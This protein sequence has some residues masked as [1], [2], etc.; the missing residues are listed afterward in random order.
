VY[1]SIK[2][3]LVHA[4]EKAKRW[5]CSRDHRFFVLN[6]IGRWPLRFCHDRSR[7]PVT[8][9]LRATKIAQGSAR[10]GRE[11]NTERGG[12]SRK[13]PFVVAKRAFSAYNLTLCKSALKGLKHHGR[14]G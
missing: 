11:G 13:T 1:D 5:A 4:A 7:L 10:G 12:I 9:A 2:T 14:D 8:A 6:N 3:L